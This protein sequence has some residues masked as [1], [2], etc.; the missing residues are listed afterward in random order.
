M[1]L[2]EGRGRAKA[3]LS[4]CGPRCGK[5]LGMRPPAHR[6]PGDRGLPADSILQAVSLSLMQN[7]V[8]GF[9]GHEP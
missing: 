4:G 1:A 5:A 9:W 3:S 2:A 7:Q 6:L 8:P